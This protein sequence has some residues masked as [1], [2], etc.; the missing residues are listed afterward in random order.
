MSELNVH[1]EELSPVVRRLQ[2]DVPAD[3][4]TRVAESVYKRLGQQVKI[5]G[6]RQGHVPR[7]VVEKY[8]ADRVR[9]D[10]AREV[11]QT[12]FEEALRTV[13]LTPVS[14]PTVEPES[15]K[16]GEGFRYSARIE[17]RP[18]VE[19]AL[20]KGLEVSVEDA[21]VAEEAVDAR[22]EAIRLESSNLVPIEGREEAQTGDFANVSWELS[23]EGTSR[24]PQKSEGGLVRVEPGLF[25]E[26]HGEKVTGQKIGETREFTEEFSG[27]R[28]D[29]LKGKTASLKVTLTGLKKRELPALDDEFAKD[30][31]GAESLAELRVKVRKDLEAAANKEQEGAR[32]EALIDQLIEKNPIE[33]PPALVDMTAT[34]MS[35]DF[36]SSILQ[37][38]VSESRIDERHPLVDRIKKDAVP[39]ATREMKTYFLLDAVADA[40]QISIS[41]DDLTNRIKE[42]ATEQ[43][44]PEAKVSARY[45]TQEAVSRL[46]EMVRSERAMVVLESNAKVTVTPRKAKEEAPSLTAGESTTA[47]TESS[48]NG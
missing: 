38:D 1:V 31:G 20:Y 33:V 11:V 28:A 35:V 9:T 24:E 40:E 25:L 22:I 8:F 16:M 32:R 45:K 30:V 13:Q 7:R 37:R 47:A 43:N 12:T 6:Y 29:E 17:V 27:E 42:I 5:P 34:R 19:L 2:I 23:V 48:A 46:A 4:V 36:L 39:R 3:R 15:L 18:K 26:G 14:E 10:V 21:S 41:A 44:V